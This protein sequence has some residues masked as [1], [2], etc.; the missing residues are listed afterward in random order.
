VLP[1][2]NTLLTGPILPFIW[3]PFPN[4]AYYD[5]QIWLVSALQPQVLTSASM[6]IFSARLTG[7]SY[8]IKVKG[9]PNGVYHWR[10]AATDASGA[11]I[12]P[13]TPEQTVTIS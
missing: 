6:T 2:P 5:L 10:M 9:M 1:G 12:S 7:T 11:L 8:Q 13:W 4:A 3:K